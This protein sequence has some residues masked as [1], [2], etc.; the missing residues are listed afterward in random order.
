MSNITLTE[1]QHTAAS[2]MA[3]YQR[4]NGINATLGEVAG[5]LGISKTTAYEHINALV[6]KGVAERI[7]K[8]G[9]SRS[10]RILA[11]FGLGIDPYAELMEC[12]R[13][14]VSWFDA[15]TNMPD[16]VAALA[17][18]ISTFDEGGAE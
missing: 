5:H 3:T 8:P 16:P 1:Q 7:G 12:A 10:V 15:D 4:R 14:V 13:Q 2:Y 6:D 9:A 11:E 18:A 17:A